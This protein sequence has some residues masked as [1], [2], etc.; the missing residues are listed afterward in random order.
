MGDSR[1]QSLRRSASDVTFGI[2]RLHTFC[3]SLPYRQAGTVPPEP[4][5]PEVLVMNEF[6]RR[7]RRVVRVVVVASLVAV[8]LAAPALYFAVEEIQF[9]LVGMASVRVTTCLSV[10]IPLVGVLRGIRPV[11]DAVVRRLGPGWQRELAARYGLDVE[12]VRELTAH[13]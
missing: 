11:A 12:Q 7:S 4:P 10:G 3:V 6:A 1:A 8:V 13:L 2:F 9:A 5:D